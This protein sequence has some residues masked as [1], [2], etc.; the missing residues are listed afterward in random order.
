M[1]SAMN[2]V[3]TLDST[4]VHDAQ[5][6]AIHARLTNQSPAPLVLNTLGLDFPSIVL[7]VLDASGKRV[8]TL[9]PPVPPEDDGKVGRKTLAKGESLRLD[10]TGNSLFSGALA[11]GEYRLR[12]FFRE[13]REGQSQDWEGELASDWVRFTVK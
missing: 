10:F 6:L 9:P 11:P 3:L 2:V 5:S 8:P 13:T 1:N 7:E 12:Y 4:E